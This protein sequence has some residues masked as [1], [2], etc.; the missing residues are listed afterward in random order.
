MGH[1]R[2]LQTAGRRRGAR[3]LDTAK[4]N[5]TSAENDLDKAFV[6]APISGTVLEILAKV[7]ERPGAAGVMEIGDIDRMTVEIEVYQSQI[8]QVSQGAAVELT[9]EAFA[10]PLMATVSRIGLEVG[11]QVLVDPAPAANTD[12][13]V[14]KVYADLDPQ[15]S[16]TARNYTNLQVT[17]RIAAASAP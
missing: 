12:A 4:A 14:I 3:N 15:S 17:A 13:R 1:A 10:K 16:K 5:L 2:R 9:A 7:G 11:R 6:R 8:G